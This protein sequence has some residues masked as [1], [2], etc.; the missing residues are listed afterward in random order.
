ME[1]IFP[2]DC[3]FCLAGFCADPNKQDEIISRLTPT[4]PPAAPACN[5]IQDVFDQNGQ[6]CEWINPALYDGKRCEDF[7]TSDRYVCETG[8]EQ[9]IGSRGLGQ[10]RHKRTSSGA[11][12]CTGPLPTR[13]ARDD[14]R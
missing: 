14:L 12:R 6:G 10:C 8:E 7:V 13:L 11:I 5:T 2:D 4:P 3:H 9:Q 1:P